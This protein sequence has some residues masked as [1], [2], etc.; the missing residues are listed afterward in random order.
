MSRNSRQICRKVTRNCLHGGISCISFRFWKRKNYKHF[1]ING[2]INGVNLNIEKS[3]SFNLVNKKKKKWQIFARQRNGNG[4]LQ[5]AAFSRSLPSLSEGRR[6]PLN[7][8]DETVLV[9]D[10]PLSSRPI[11]P[12]PHESR[13]GTIRRRFFLPIRGA[14]FTERLRNVRERGRQLQAATNVRQFRSVARDTARKRSTFR[15]FQSA[16]PPNLST[17]TFE[18]VGRKIQPLLGFTI[19]L[20]KESSVGRTL[21]NPAID[22]DNI[23]GPMR[24][25]FSKS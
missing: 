17:K 23:I 7:L 11:S 14:R 25:V 9:E 21:S 3:I 5:V 15:E 10:Y 24:R 20:S 6:A 2:L 12:S 16:R 19:D 8:I 1:Y 22:S 18:T 13:K 4:A